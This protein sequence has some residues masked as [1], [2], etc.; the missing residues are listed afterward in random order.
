MNR[1]NRAALD[2]R[3][4]RRPMRVVKPGWLSR[5]LAV[6][7]ALRPLGVELQH[8]VANDLERHPADPGRLRARRAFVNRCQSQKPPRLRAV[9]RSPRRRP[10]H[11]R[12]KI[13]PKRNGHAEPPSFATV[14]QNP[15]DSGSPNR[16]T[17]SEIRYQAIGIIFSRK[18]MRAPDRPPHRR[19]KAEPAISSAFRPAQ[20]SWRIRERPRAC[21]SSNAA[22]AAS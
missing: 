4:E 14:N 11:L 19:G 12:I 7:Q 1:R 8:P 9:L 5:R 22:L 2:D 15:A 18:L 13:S 6:D 17:P 16:V 21:A 3:G 20:S 10:H